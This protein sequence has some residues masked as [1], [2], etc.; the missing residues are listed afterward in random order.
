LILRAVVLYKHVLPTSIIIGDTVP[1]TFEVSQPDG[2]PYDLT[3]HTVEF[4]VKRSRQD[5]DPAALINVSLDAGIVFT[6]TA[7]QGVVTVTLS[8]DRTSL[9]RYG[10]LYYWQLRLTTPTGE[11][12]TP[13]E[14]TLL[15]LN[16]GPLS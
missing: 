10:R 5:S 7:S 15:A 2:D 13:E 1:L 12:F 6:Y 4:L 16:D 11:I 14:G 9:L 3:D 8:S